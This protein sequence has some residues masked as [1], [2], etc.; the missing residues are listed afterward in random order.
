MHEHGHVLAVGR[1]RREP[2]AVAQARKAAARAYAAYPRID[3]SLVELL[4]SEAATN[5]VLHAEGPDFYVLCHSPCPADGSV[6]VEVHDGG[7][8]LPLRRRAAEL[9]ESGRGLALLDL[10]A[11]DRRTERTPM[12]KCLIFTLREAE[13]RSALT[14]AEPTHAGATRSRGGDQE[15]V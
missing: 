5:A 8:A 1:Y 10:L 7:S 6:Q 14:A 11:A 12:G 2:A 3:R 4:V 9:D 13:S 15:P